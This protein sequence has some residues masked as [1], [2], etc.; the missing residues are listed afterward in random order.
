MRNC[1]I[2][3]IVLFVTSIGGCGGQ[4]P[5]QRFNA[6]HGGKTVSP[7]GEI[8][9]GSAHDLGDGWVQFQTEDGQTWK[10]NEQ[11]DGTFGELKSVQ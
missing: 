11:P 2:L 1:L 4:T 6:L 8:V 9:E 3:M 5:A 10:V 7:Y